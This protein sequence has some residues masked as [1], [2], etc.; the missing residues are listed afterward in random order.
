MV[1]RFTGPA[2]ASRRRSRRHARALGNLRREP[3]PGHGSLGMAGSLVSYEAAAHP[4]GANLVAKV[5][6]SDSART[7]VEHI[8]DEAKATTRRLLEAN[9]HL[10]EALRDALLEREELVGEEILDVIRDAEDASTVVDLRTAVTDF[11]PGG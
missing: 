2:A 4:G 11:I 9:R 1:H 10:V 3:S 6:A 8:L 7:E 5:L